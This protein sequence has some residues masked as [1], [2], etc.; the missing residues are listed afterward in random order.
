MCPSP[1]PLLSLHSQ[2]EELYL[3]NFN[4]LAKENPT[5]QDEK[6]QVTKTLIFMHVNSE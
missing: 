3:S 2:T 1:G 4:S 5:V 6:K